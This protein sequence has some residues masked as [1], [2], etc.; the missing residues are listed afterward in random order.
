MA[1][2]GYA[3]LG[4]LAVLCAC[5]DGA[6]VSPDPDP[7]APGASIFAQ[8]DLNQDY[9]FGILGRDGIASLDEPSW[10]RADQ[11]IPD[12]PD[13]DS[14]IIGVAVS[15]ITYA[16]PHSVL[17]SHEIVNATIGGSA[18]I[19]VTYCPLTGSSL[20]F[21]RTSVD[22]AE[23]GVSGLLFMNNLIVHDRREPDDSLWP[24]MLAEAR[25]GSRT[26]SKLTQYTFVEM[27]WASW[28][29]LH[30]ETWVLADAENQGLDPRVVDYS[31]FGYPYGEYEDAKTY[32]SEGIVPPPDQRRFSW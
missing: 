20:V 24:L 22:G 26:G 31:L 4:A 16:I 1:K 7:G 18:G 12:Y 5:G 23:L 25:C 30:P 13:P 14:R 8:C 27:R 2:A 11:G 15:G 6:A 9:L 19:A 21:D 29:A 28:L 32:F 10:E 17:W 3:R